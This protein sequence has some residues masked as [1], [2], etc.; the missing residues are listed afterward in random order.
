MEQ[1]E[2]GRR[3]DLEGVKGASRSLRLLFDWA[4]H[5]LN[6]KDKM[7][8]DEEGEIFSEYYPLVR[9]EMELK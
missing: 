5:R 3:S 6:M 7:C 9:R 1:I 4:P 8:K 2:Y